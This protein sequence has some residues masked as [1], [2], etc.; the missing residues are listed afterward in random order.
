MRAPLPWRTPLTLLEREKE[1]AAIA[2]ARSACVLISGPAGIGKTRAARRSVERPTPVLRARGSELE[3]SFAFGGVQQLFARVKVP[4]EGAAAHARAAFAA[5]GEPD[6]AVL[7]GLYWLTVSQ[8]PLT[9]VVD[10]AH[11]LDRQSLRWLAYMVNRVA[12]LPLTILLAARSDEPDELLTRIALHPSTTTLTPEAAQR[13]TAVARARGRRARRRD[14]RGHGREPVL[15][16]R[17]A[18]RPRRRTPKPVIES[19]ALRL[20]ALPPACGKLARAIAVAGSGGTIAARLAGLDV[21]Q[22]VEAAE[23]LAHADL[24]RGDGFAHPLVQQAVYA[25]IPA[26]ERAELHAAAAR[27]VERPRAGRRARDGRRARAAASWAAHALRDG[28]ATPPGRAAR[29]TSPPAS[30]SAPPRRSSPRDELV[31]VLRELARALIATEGPEGFPVLR[32]ALALA[33]DERREI[34]LE[35]GHAL[36]VQGY[37]STAPRSS[38]RPGARGPSWRP[39]RC[40]TSR[41][42]AASAASTALASR[43]PPGP[44]GGRRLDRGRARGRPRA[45][46]P[47]RPRRRCRPRRRPSFPGVLIALM[48]AGRL[49]QAD[50]IWTGAADAARARGELETLRLAVALRAQIRMRQGRVA[51]VEADLRELIAWV[52]ELDLP[53]AELR[54]A[55]PW[56]IAPLVDA[57]IERGELDEAAALGD[58]D[59]PRPRTGRRCSASRSCST[60]SRGCGWRRAAWPRRSGSRASA[61]RRQRAWGIRN[62]GFLPWGSTLAA[63]LHATGRTTEALDV[64]DQQ[65]DLARAFGVAREHGMGAARAR[66]DHR[67]CGHAARRR[68]RAARLARPARARP[69]ADGAAA[70]A[71]RCARRSSSPS[72]AARPRSP[73]APATSSSPPARGRAARGSPTSPPPRSA[74]R[75]WRPTASATAQ[76][77]EALWVTEKTV[78]GHLGAAYRKLGHRLAQPA[79]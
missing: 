48:G 24:L 69:R 4:D 19:I 36:L 38:S 3:R 22:A 41:S 33:G 45:R 64:C 67:R 76:I 5:G 35:L 49:E 27:L 30:S 29:P 34:A 16:A 75:G 68:R 2:Q 18:R 50:A 62:P 70:A 66:H 63:A 8:G 12:E 55:L 1:R 56:V 72:A 26:A 28:R 40:S 78:E 32:E 23:A 9:L 57:L 17:A 37:F 65:I 39:S 25:A 6:H 58:G 52:G 11:W 44:S 14:P 13:Q 46:A 47:T 59:R 21:R 10:D 54:M 7:H 51:E 77:A 42:S 15:R 79:R 60:A 43:R 74:S 73:P 61:R 20:D 71:R 53:Y 31:P